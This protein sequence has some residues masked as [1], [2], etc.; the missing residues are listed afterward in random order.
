MYRK[1]I[2]GRAAVLTG[3]IS[4]ATMLT[5]SIG[6]RVAL[7]ADGR[8]LGRES[9]GGKAH[10]TLLYAAL[11]YISPKLRARR[12]K[13]F[14]NLFALHPGLR[15][16]DLGGAS[17]IW[18][19]V[20]V[21][22]DITIVNLPGFL[23]DQGDPTKHRFT[24]LEADAT[25][26]PQ[27]ADNSFD[28]VFSNSVIEHVGDASHR[29]AFAR[30]AARLAPRY[31]IQTPSIWFPVEP[32]CGVPFWW[33]LPKA[34]RARMHREWARDVP[35]W[36]EM[37]AGTTVLAVSELKR[38]FPN[39][40]LMVERWLGLPKSNTSFGENRWPDRQDYSVQTF[41]PKSRPLNTP[42]TSANKPSSSTS[43]AR[44]ASPMSR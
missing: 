44:A 23:A 22:L 30:E 43:P 16:C 39:S 42:F 31:Y 8:E 11:N 12:M 17:R 10:R 18:N 27:F 9:W 4:K 29:A 1:R 5:H 24:F 36:N 13:T 25:S 7:K 41:R 35:A 26:L 3:K 19:S 2:S 34:L 32:H 15:I 40:T 6:G 37:V 28:L 38:L 33:F 14:T 20:S 21:P